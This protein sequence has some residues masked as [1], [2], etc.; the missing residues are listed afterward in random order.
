[1]KPPMPYSGGKQRVADAIA[2]LL[3]QHDGYI[4]PFAGALSVLLAKHP[5]PLEVVNDLDGDIVAFWRV[6]RDRPADLERA[7]ALTPHSR[8]ETQN[9]G[10]LGPDVDE[11][12][13]ARRV[14]VALTQRRAAVLRP[15]AGWRFVHGANG[16]ALSAYLEGYVARIAP[17]AERLKRVSLECRPAL[18]VIASYGSHASNLLYVDP[19]YL[20]DTRAM[21]KGQYRHELQG[22]REHSVL[23]EALLDAEAM[24]ALSGYAHPLYDEALTGWERREFAAAS[25]MGQPR[26]EVLWMNYRPADTLDFGEVTA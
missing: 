20:G 12:E 11:V 6:L 16:M 7:C 25:A 24:V 10:N 18:D 14:W 26:V 23:L 19:P 9:A 2:A 21:S 13:R 5:S 3:P 4:E 8:L 1:M 15:A 22:T 17:A